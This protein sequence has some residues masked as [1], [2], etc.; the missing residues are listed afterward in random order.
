L[1]W[2]V[3]QLNGFLRFVF[4]VNAFMSTQPVHVAMM[5]CTEGLVCL[6]LLYPGPQVC[7]LIHAEAAQ[8]EMD[9]LALAEVLVPCMAWKPPAKP[10]NPAG[11]GPWQGLAK[12]L[13]LNKGS[14]AAA[15][16]GLQTGG[17]DAAAGA[18]AGVEV[19]EAAAAAAVRA[20]EEQQQHEVVALEDAELEAVVTVVEYM[21]SNY[22]S[23][24]GS[25]A[26]SSN[27]SSIGT[28]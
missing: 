3:G 27:G 12:A 7:S 11:P 15:A 23:V 1:V 26:Q 18:G 13:A 24:F 17:V 28:A 4:T 5:Y 6:L 10:Q 22:G 9:A 16:A 14:G 8:N 19:E 20:T 21:I 2:S 25:T